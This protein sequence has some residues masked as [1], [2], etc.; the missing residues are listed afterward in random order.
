MQRN[1]VIHVTG[2]THCVLPVWIGVIMALERCIGQMH[3]SPS[4]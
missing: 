4:R 3:Y 1:G 2:R